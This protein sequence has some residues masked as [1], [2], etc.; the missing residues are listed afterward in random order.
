MLKRNSTAMVDERHDSPTRNESEVIFTGF[1]LK[2]DIVSKMDEEAASLGVSRNALASI[3]FAERYGV[4]ERA[5]Q[6]SQVAV[7]A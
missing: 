2:S 5:L 6:S 4:R 3:V 1:R 7:A